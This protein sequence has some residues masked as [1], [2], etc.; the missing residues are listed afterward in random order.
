M[1][2]NYYRD[3]EAGRRFLSIEKAVEL[4]NVFPF[5]AD[6]DKL[7]FFWH[8]FKDTLPEEIHGKLLLPRV[9]NSFKTLKESR[10]ILEYDLKIHREAA[11]IARS[12]N[13]QMASD[14]IVNMLELNIDFLPTIHYIYMKDEVTG[15]QLSIICEN[16]NIIFDPVVIDKFLSNVGV[17]IFENKNKKFYRRSKPVFR[18]PRTREGI[19][20]KDKFTI[21][22]INKSFQKDRG[23]ESFDDKDTFDYSGIYAIPKEARSRLT[24]RL[25]DLI[26]ELSVANKQLD[27]PSSVPFFVSIILSA[28]HEYDA[29]HLN[30]Q[31]EE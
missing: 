13:V 19:K 6:E 5:D 24:D 7:E 27:D 14:S 18:I 15:E 20:F 4:Y 22:E 9:D 23:C 30:R 25:R 10:E 12:E 21:L 31:Q 26:S 16:N 28:R 11:A 17:E 8:Y 2:P 1:S 29:D 3:V